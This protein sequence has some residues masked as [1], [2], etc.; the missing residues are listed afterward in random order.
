[1]SDGSVTIPRAAA[2]A[3][4]VA[5]AAGP[6]GAGFA[7]REPT[8]TLA[9]ELVDVRLSLESL[10]ADVRALAESQGRALAAI[11]DER[12]E[13]RALEERVRRLEAKK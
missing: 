4:V 13:R 6:T 9:R 10:R 8:E 7:M 3:A 1:M 12:A 2:W 5:L 11:S